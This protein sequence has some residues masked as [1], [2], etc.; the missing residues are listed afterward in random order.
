VSLGNGAT[1]QYYTTPV[2]GTGATC[3]GNTITNTDIN[4]RCVTSTG[5]SNGI[6]ERS[7]VRTAAFAAVPLFP[8]PGLIGLK[9]VG[10]TGNGTTTGNSTSNG[11]VSL[12]GNASSG[13]IVLGP[14]GSYTHTG[15][16]SGGGVT[17][18]TSPVVLSPVDPG[19][20]NQTLLS[21]CPARQ[22]AGY[23]ACN[24]DY[25]I[26]NGLASTKVTPYDPSSGNVSFDASTRT[27]SMSGNS[28]LTL[29]GGLYNFCSISASGGATITTAAGAQTEV[30]IDSPD[31]PGSGCPSGSGNFSMTGGSNWQNLNS[32]SLD[33]QIYVYG[34]NDDSGTVTLTGNAAFYGVIYAPQSQVSL[35]GNG[36][37]IG[38]VA[39]YTTTITGNGLTWD[40]QDST[41]QASALGL[42]YR[43]AWA[44]C[45]PTSP[46]GTNP[47]AG[48]G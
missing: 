33:L 23:P 11:T 3:V 15:N 1:Y 27:L 30:F 20:S 32:D 45:T 8:E 21:A 38:G 29:G 44:Q 26:T 16:A 24:D 43:T 25:R 42:F 17:N 2:L 28:T 36:R 7:Q 6:V 47:G 19:S 39:G 31:D 46:S 41:L 12:T 18:L 14:A 5:T 10:L 37:V 40:G 48:C 13:G 34:L 22:A 4:Q 35:T 9:S